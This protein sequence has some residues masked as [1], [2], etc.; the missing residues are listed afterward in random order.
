MAF[1]L[2]AFSNVTSGATL[3]PKVWS[4]GSSDTLATI[5]ASGF[6]D[7]VSERIN[8]NDL[9]YAKGTDGAEFVK[10][11]SAKGVVPVTIDVYIPSS[12]GGGSSAITQA[13]VV[14]TSPEILDMLN[15]PVLLVAA[16]GAGKFLL[17]NSVTLVGVSGNV[18]YTNGDVMFVSYDGFSGI[19]AYEDI[20]AS[21]VT[22]SNK[23]TYAVP[24]NYHNVV[25]QNISVNKGIYIWSGGATPFANGN[26]TLNVYISYQTITI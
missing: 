14:V 6:F 10:F 20:P 1:N 19:S 16:P 24:I 17:I 7:E 26:G 9:L 22:T 25:N 18:A 3:G 15:T 11:T 13:K 12:G 23:L 8:V 21:A 4:Y 2:E 5:E